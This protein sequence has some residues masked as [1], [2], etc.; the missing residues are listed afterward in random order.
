M[1]HVLIER[2]IAPGM[3]STYE[4]NCV[5]AL[6]QICVVKG[7][8]SGETFADKHDEN[9]R[10]VFCKWRNIHAWETWYRS[11]ERMELMNTINPILERP[12]KITVLKNR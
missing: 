10:Y 7:Y 8:I 11:R 1:I 5:N 9:H 4:T 12:E 2:Y 3:L 6:Q